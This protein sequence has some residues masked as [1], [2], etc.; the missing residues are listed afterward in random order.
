MSCCCCKRGQSTIWYS[1]CLEDQVWCALRFGYC[2]QGRQNVVRVTMVPV[3]RNY[4]WCNWPALM[5]GAYYFVSGTKFYLHDAKSVQDLPQGLPITSM[6][7]LRQTTLFRMVSV[8]LLW[9]ATVHV[10]ESWSP[11][12]TG[13]AGRVTKPP[14]RSVPGTKEE[15]QDA[16]TGLKN[17]STFFYYSV[18]NN[19]ARTK[20]LYLVV[21]QAIPYGHAIVLVADCVKQVP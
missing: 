10:K 1:S 7:P 14:C 16:P 6:P 8:A 18:L 17:D 20:N 12:K 4:C 13:T 21:T 9:V 2:V 5:E 15:V 19:T 3:N 11:C